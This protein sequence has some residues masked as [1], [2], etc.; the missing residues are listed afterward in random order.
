MRS[1]E[2]ADLLAEK[3]RIMDEEA[4]LLREKSKEAENE[5]GRIKLSAIKVSYRIR[6]NKR[7][8]RLVNPLQKGALIGMENVE[9]G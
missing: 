6:H 7:L 8:G 1:E 2:T 4:L 3:V 5:V 9:G